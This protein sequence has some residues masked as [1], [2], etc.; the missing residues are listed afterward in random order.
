MAQLSIGTKMVSLQQTQSTMQ[1]RTCQVL[2]KFLNLTSKYL[3]SSSIKTQKSQ[4]ME[5][6]HARPLK[7]NLLACRLTAKQQSNISTLQGKVQVWETDNQATKLTLMVNPRSNSITIS[8]MPLIQSTFNSSR[9]TAS[10][11][12]PTVFR[13]EHFLL[14]YPL[15]KRR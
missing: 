5:V 9:E 4:T 7:R 1:G 12:K 10:I 14:P 13:S 2:C 6:V 8:M 3:L 15:T 11:R